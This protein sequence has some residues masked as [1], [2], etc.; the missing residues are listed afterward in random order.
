MVEEVKAIGLNLPISFKKSIEICDFIRYKNLNNVKALL[1]GVL[2]KKTAIPYKRFNQDTPHRRGRIAAGRYPLRTVHYFLKLIN[3]LEANA[4]NK[5]FSTEG[6]V[7][8]Y[9]AANKGETQW[10]TGRQRRRLMKRSHL[11]LRAIEKEVKKE[12]KKKD[13]KERSQEKQFNREEKND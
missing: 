9:A 12:K 3:T 11:E 1:N 10:H 13:K 8:I 4:E 6:L 5:G 2:E 7:I